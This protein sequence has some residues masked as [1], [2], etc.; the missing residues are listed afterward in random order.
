MNFPSGLCWGTFGFGGLEGDGG[1]GGA[2]AG[3]IVESNSSSGYSAGS[4]VEGWAGGEGPVAGI[5]KITTPSDSS[6]LQGVFGFSGVGVSAGPLAGAQVGG[7]M[8]DHW[9]GLYIEG[10]AGPWALGGGAYIGT[11]CSKGPDAS[12]GPDIFP[13]QDFSL[14]WPPG[15]L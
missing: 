13:R 11:D 2:F 15:F 4:L 1:E 6:P 14:P 8:G 7:A 10:H 3:G 5:G 12:K 9:A